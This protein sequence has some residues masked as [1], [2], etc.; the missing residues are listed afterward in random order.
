MRVPLLDHHIVE[1]VM[2]LPDSI[3]RPNGYPKRLLMESLSCGLPG[4]IVDRPKQG[5]VLPFD[6][7]MRA[8]LR[9]LCEHHLGP[10]GLQKLSIFRS[11]GLQSVW[12]SF[13]ARDGSVTWS[14]PW[15]LVALG[16]WIE[17]LQLKA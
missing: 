4:D 7:W 11:E 16:A 6:P 17:Q 5:F 3:K 2:G 9:P 12:S 13:L 1:Y 10:D 14:R 15:T 8:E